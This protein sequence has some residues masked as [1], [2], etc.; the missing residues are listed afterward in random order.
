MSEFA[1][2]IPQSIENLQLPSPE[3]LNYYKDVENRVFYIESEIDGSLLEITKE[4]LRINRADKDV[5]VEKRTPIKLMIDS[6]GGDVSIMWSFIKVMEMSKTPIWTINMCCAYSAAADILAA[7]H[8]RFAMPGTSVLVHSGSCYYGGTQ[9][10]AESMKK[11]G[12]KLTKSV[13]EYFLAHTKVDPKVFKKKAPFDWYMLDDEALEM[14][15]VD[16]IITNL[17]EIF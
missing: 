16:E 1:I 8:R 17:D 5:P 13:T 15:I 9:E 7:G 12:D 2:A 11:F 4:I 10:I 14:G 3:L 6:P